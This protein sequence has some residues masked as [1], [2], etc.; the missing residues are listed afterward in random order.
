MRRTIGLLLGLALAFGATTAAAGKNFPDRIDLPNGWAPEGI[1]SGTG[2][3]VFVGSLA[4]GAIWRGDTRTGT[5]DV[6]IAGVPGRVAVGIEYEAGADRLWV[7][8]GGTSQVRA[9]DASSGALLASYDFVSGFLN[10]VVAT[11]DAIYVTDSNMQQLIVIPLGPGGSL[12]APGGA[13]TLPLTG[14]LVYDPAAFNANGIVAARGWLILVQSGEGLL[15]RV[16]PATGMTTELDLG[17]YSVTTGDGLELRG[18]TLYVV[19][20]RMNLVAALRLGPGLTSASLQAEFGAPSFD[21]PTTATRSAGDLWAVNARFGT[22]VTPD[23]E[24]WITRV[25]GT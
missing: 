4:D 1:T 12:P 9:Y 15:F 3:T 2:T 6:F 8:G 16:D 20:N 24:Y 11:P 18:S 21:V 7:A 22:P 17:G 23:T 5:G 25:P 19:R 13:T 14:D 10:D